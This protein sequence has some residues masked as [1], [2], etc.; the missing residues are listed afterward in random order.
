MNL[1]EARVTVIG[2]GLMGGSMARA[3]TGRCRK[4]IGVDLN[5]SNLEQAVRC[6]AV[7]LGAKDSAEGLA[8][9]DLAILAVPVCEIIH[10]LD[11][12]GD[13]LPAPAFLMDLGSTKVDITNSM[14]ALP[15]RVD[16]IGGHPFCGKETA[17]FNASESDLFRGAPFVLT[18]LPRTSPAC[19][20]LA[21]Q[22]IARIGARAIEVEAERHD[23]IIAV[24]SHLP[25]LLAASLTAL[26]RDL[27]RE[28]P[29]YRELI[30]GGF[31]DATRV[32][33]SDLRMIT[34]VLLTN[35]YNLGHA[36]DHVLDFLNT[37]RNLT[38]SNQGA[39]LI[40]LLKPI[41]K[42]RSELTAPVEEGA[43]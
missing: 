3:L 12:I 15:D 36:L 38:Q 41:Q 19:L 35:G 18:P 43:K 16:P 21:R 13:D 28:D 40:K 37:M 4:L 24:T 25:Y 23:R 32:A 27:E 14:D 1:E 22:L 5:P 6:G 11:R 34:D 7:D 39:A 2:L 20:R 10:I 29:F 30:A 9:C 42:W 31:I 8:A 33:A 17:G 26:C